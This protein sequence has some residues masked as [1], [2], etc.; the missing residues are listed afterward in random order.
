MYARDFAAPI[1]SGL[2]TSMLCDVTSYQALMLKP[3]ALVICLV[4]QST[5]G[6]I[7]PQVSFLVALTLASRL[8]IAF[9][10]S[11]GNILCHAADLTPKSCC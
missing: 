10:G 1:S 4:C 11:N 6:E 5:M 7:I 8:E 3:F 2:A 9:G